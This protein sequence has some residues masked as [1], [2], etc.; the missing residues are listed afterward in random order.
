MIQHWKQQ[1]AV[2]NPNPDNR[3]QQ[4]LPA[5]WLGHLPFQKQSQ[6]DSCALEDMQ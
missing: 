1:T 3:A 5:P 2:I 6:Q 4:L